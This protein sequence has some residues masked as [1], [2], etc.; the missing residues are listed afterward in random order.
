MAEKH[1]WTFVVG[2]QGGTYVSQFAATNLVDAIREYN[3]S[4]PSGRMAIPIKE[5]YVPVSDMTNV[6]CASGLCKGEGKLILAHIIETQNL[7]SN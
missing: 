5:E 3:Q 4:D 7:E 2:Y 6:F 1:L